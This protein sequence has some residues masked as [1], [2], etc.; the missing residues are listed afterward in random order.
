MQQI[1]G[2]YVEQTSSQEYLV[3]QFSPTSIPLRQRWRNTGLSADFLADYWATFFP[4]HDV[5]SREQRQEI[6]GAINYVANELLEN[7]MKF[8][9]KPADIPV[10]LGLY[11]HEDAFRFYARNA[12]DPQGVEAFQVRIQRLL[13]EDTGE[14]FMQQ[15]EKNV[16]DEGGS[17]SHLGLLTMIND[18]GARLAWMFESD[19]ELGATT[20]TTMVELE[21]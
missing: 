4:A 9:F 19:P 5:P 6:K 17:E 8:S 10:S 20:V 1:F 2:D 21:V 11:L 12:V 3:I 14:L 16:A 13:T 18:Y 15:L 7:V